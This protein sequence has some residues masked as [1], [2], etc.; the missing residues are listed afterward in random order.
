MRPVAAIFLAAL[1]LSSPALA[2]FTAG[3]RA[4]EAGD[5]ATALK[6]WR[7]LAED[8][9]VA[10]QRNLGQMYRL[11]QGVERDAVE[12]ARWYRKAAE[13]GFDRAQ[14][15]LAALYMA[16][17]GVDRDPAKAA[18]WFEQAA[19][20]GH[21]ISQFNLGLMYET[22]MGVPRDLPRALGW[23][24]LAARSGHP[25]AIEKLSQLVLEAPPPP[26]V[27][28]AGARETA[29]PAPA[30]AAPIVP[31][32]DT[33]ITATALPEPPKT[34]APLPE[35]AKAAPPP[36]AA[37]QPRPRRSY[38][39]ESDMPGVPR[40]DL[41]GMIASLFEDDDEPSPASTPA[42]PAQAPE[43]NRPAPP[44]IASAPPSKLLT[45]PR[46]RT[47]DA[48]EIR[49][50]RDEAIAAGR[51]ERDAGNAQKAVER[52]LPLAEGGDA[53]AQYLVGTAFALGE[54]Q[55]RDPVRA[56]MWLMLAAQGGHGEA[57][58]P[59]AALGRELTEQQRADGMTLVRNFRPATAAP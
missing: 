52:W 31:K 57:E 56:F 29:E 53:E 37:P 6:E 47:L 13:I 9:D 17:E 30:A 25:Q 46:P 22:G 2:D 38:R 23:L 3:T 11:G 16:G 1:L 19:R 55:A 10:A 20:Q 27:A 50:R 39:S 15:N 33:Q 59:A 5:Y 44:L 54:G 43:A 45:A 32:P 21:V 48:T 35:P 34:A 4:Y 42:P 58:G 7:P 14:A 24:N 18:Y 26:A 36:A 12:A 28:N 51:R 40:Y 49:A 8:G 41:F